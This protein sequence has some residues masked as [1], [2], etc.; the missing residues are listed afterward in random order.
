MKKVSEKDL[1][2]ACLYLG[3]GISTALR[4]SGLYIPIASFTLSAIWFFIY[5]VDKEIE[6]QQKRMEKYMEE[7]KND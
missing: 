7:H 6:R 3:L 4:G 2:M 5:S 1:F